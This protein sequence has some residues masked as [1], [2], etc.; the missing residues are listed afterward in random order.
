MSK[1]TQ[2]CPMP[3]SRVID[4]YFMEHRAKLIDIAAFLD[5]CERAEND[6]G[7]QDFRIAALRDGAL[8][9]FDGRPDRA[10]R[11]LDLLSDPTQ[12]PIASAAGMKGARGASPPE[13]QPSLQRSSP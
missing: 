1:S 12:D 10:R 5:R 2:S 6:V 3:L 11:I 7:Q 8:M 13:R 4:A 9:L